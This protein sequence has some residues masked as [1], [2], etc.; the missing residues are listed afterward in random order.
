MKSLIGVAIGHAHR[1]ARKREFIQ[2]AS[3]K[4]ML[5]VLVAVAFIV[6]SSF[7][8][9]DSAVLLGSHLG[10]NHAVL[11]MIILA[12]VTSIPNVIAAVFLAHEGRGAAVVSESLNSNTLNILVGICIPALV[13]GFAPPSSPI[14]YA[15]IWLMFMKFITLF[16]AS[17]RHGL[18]R[19]DGVLILLL[20]LVFVLAVI[21][22]E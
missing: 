18:H 10:I 9:V 21:M 19:K 20:Y 2:H 17:S 1:D 14:I 12:A 6:G 7:S 3:W 16:I 11:G 13:I 5:W 15:A 8:A 4:D 22:W